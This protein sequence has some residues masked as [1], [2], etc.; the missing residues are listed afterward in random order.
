VRGEAIDPI[1][2]I[3]PVDPIDPSIHRS[4]DPSDPSIQSIHRSIDPVDPV[5]PS[6]SSRLTGAADELAVISDGP[7]VIVYQESVRSFSGC[8]SADV[9]RVRTRTGSAAGT[10]WLSGH[11]P[12]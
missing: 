9:E 12:K 4:I 7:S 3:D 11:R 8:P 1:D 2:L 5:D 6:I 10:G